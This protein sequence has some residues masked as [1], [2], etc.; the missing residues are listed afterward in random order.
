MSL[1]KA[2]DLPRALTATA[3]TPNVFKDREARGQADGEVSVAL[4][5]PATPKPYTAETSPGIG[6]M[7]NGV[8]TSHVVNT[9][10]SSSRQDL[11][12]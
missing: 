9:F 8:H 10:C 11:W 6:E 2:A 3:G 5:C 7:R 4:Q 1:Q 12:S